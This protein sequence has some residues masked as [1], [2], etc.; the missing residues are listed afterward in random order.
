MRHRELPSP[1]PSPGSSERK[2]RQES[3]RDSVETSLDRNSSV[4]SVTFARLITRRIPPRRRRDPAGRGEGERSER[5][6]RGRGN[7]GGG[8]K[9]RELGVDIKARQTIRRDADAIVL[10][11]VD[12]RD[13]LSRHVLPTRFFYLDPQNTRILS[14]RVSIHRK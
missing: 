6:K 3:E 14:Y 9:N 8:E 5:K 12:R 1:L 11:L 7:G 10:R 2:T 13:P 4:I